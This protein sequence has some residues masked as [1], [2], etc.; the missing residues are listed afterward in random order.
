MSKHRSF[1]RYSWLLGCIALI[2][3]GVLP[4]RATVQSDPG[5]TIQIVQRAIS[6]GDVQALS[7]YTGTYTEISIL[8]ATTMYSRAQTAYI[9]KAFFRDHPPAQFTFQHR[10]QV[11]K[12]W[13]VHGRYWDRGRQT[14]YR[15]EM[16]MRWN[17]RQFEIKSIRIL[18]I[19]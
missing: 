5:E 8:G 3:A 6:K 14:P 19:E 12:D 17:G 10:L 13:Y 16:N 18:R 9:L 4:A 7:K 2:F 1:F 15:L 11:G